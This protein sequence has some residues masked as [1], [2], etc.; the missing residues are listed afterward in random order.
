MIKNMIDER[1]SNRYEESKKIEIKQNKS[2]LSPHTIAIYIHLKD[3]LFLRIGWCH[4]D[5]LLWF[6]GLD[7]LLGG[8][9]E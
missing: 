6:G 9:R 4:L 1:K 5:L 7:E 3:Q 2:A 8:G